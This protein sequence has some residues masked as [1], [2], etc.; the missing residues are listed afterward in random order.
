MTEWPRTTVDELAE[1]VDY[2]FTASATVDSSGP[3]FLRITDIQAGDVD[4]S[5][6]PYCSCGAG[7]LARYALA[8]GDIV[9]T[10]TGATTGKSYLIREC[11]PNTV[12][13]SYL[14]RIRP[15]SCIDSRYLA[16][17]FNTPDYWGQVASRA[18]GAGQPGINASKLKEL[19]VPIPPLSE[20]KRIAGILD[21]ADIIC[22]KRHRAIR[23]VSELP[24]SVFREMFG[25]VVTNSAKWPVEP[26]EAVCESRLGK[27]LDSKQ[28][29][30]SHR[31][32][33]LRNCNV[34]WDSFD[35]GEVLEMDFDEGDREEFA[36]MT[37]DVLICEG[38]E[39]GRSAIWRGELPECYFQKAL[40]RVRPYKDKAVSEYILHFMW[41]MARAEGFREVTSQATIAHLTGVKLKRL[42]VPLPPIDLQ[43]EFANRIA[44]CTQLHHK[45]QHADLEAGQLFDSLAQSAFRGEL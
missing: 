29:T 18:Q 38:G 37:G 17:F 16:Y 22:R 32:P 12:F 40:H 39:I 35:L 23:S 2:G 6:V 26:F 15:K 36:L 34:Q 33:Y 3:K 44:E 43:R 10:R 42:L 30:G 13:A 1:R 41:E 19:T 24:I 31:R 28:Q 45:L 20:Q 11:P 25:T 9:F 5:T 14:I 8:K 7:E 21:Q 27:M 4:W